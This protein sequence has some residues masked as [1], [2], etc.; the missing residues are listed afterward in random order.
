MDN[1]CSENSKAARYE[2]RKPFSFCKLPQYLVPGLEDF[3][4]TGIHPGAPG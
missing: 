2:E 1:F 4:L 3:L